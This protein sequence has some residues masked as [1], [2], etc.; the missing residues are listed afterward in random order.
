MRRLLILTGALVGL[1]DCSAFTGP[2]TRRIVGT[3]DPS[4][5]GNTVLAPDTVQAGSSFIAIIHTFGSSSCTTPDGVAL[6]LGSSEARITPYDLVPADK[7]TVCTAD[8]APQPHPVELRF[9]HVGPAT[10]VV[11]AAVI[12][13]GSGGQSRGVVTKQLVVI[14]AEQH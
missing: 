14:P 4:G 7:G 3:I 12:D 8:L 11:L 1:A 6:K 13:Q 10:I 2:D 9:S 5:T